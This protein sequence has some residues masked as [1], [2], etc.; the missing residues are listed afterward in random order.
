MAAKASAKPY[1]K[2]EEPPPPIPTGWDAEIGV[3][4]WPNEDANTIIRHGKC[5]GMTYGDIMKQ[6]PD[7][8]GELI[9]EE[10]RKS[11]ARKFV[12]AF[13]LARLAGGF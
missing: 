6:Y 9:R 8:P 3:K 12:R 4:A 5:V 13:V 1:P 10:C 2:A 11:N 7:Y